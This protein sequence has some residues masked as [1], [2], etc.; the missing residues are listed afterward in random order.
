MS[1]ALQYAEMPLSDIRASVQTQT[2]RRL[3]T[4]ETHWGDVLGTDKH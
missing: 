4:V 2:E 3:G 1:K